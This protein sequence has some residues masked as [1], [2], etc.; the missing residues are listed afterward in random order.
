MP[1]KQHVLSPFGVLRRIGV[2]IIEGLYMNRVV[3]RFYKVCDTICREEDN[4]STMYKQ[5]RQQK[6]I[7]VRELV[8]KL[9]SYM[10]ASL[11]LIPL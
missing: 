11:P 4:T 3:V 9:V 8:R 1:L 2:E 7:I 6:S 10:L 5:E